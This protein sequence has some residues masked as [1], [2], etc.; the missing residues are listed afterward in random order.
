[1]R[2]MV[3]RAKPARFRAKRESMLSRGDWMHVSASPV[4]FR[5][6]LCVCSMSASRRVGT[7]SYLTFSKAGL[8]PP[9][10]KFRRSSSPRANLMAR[11]GSEST[12]APHGVC[13]RPSNDDVSQAIQSIERAAGPR[14]RRRAKVA[15]GNRSRFAARKLV[16]RNRAGRS[17]SHATHPG[18][19]VRPG[20]ARLD[21]ARQRWARTSTLASWIG[22]ELAGRDDHGSKDATGATP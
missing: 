22:P 11:I 21:A 1:M 3:H 19:A 6:R 4:G 8:S 9:E 2:S 10:H 14:G 15:P 18:V 20:R 13:G 5:D 12:T 17:G 16:S 7:R